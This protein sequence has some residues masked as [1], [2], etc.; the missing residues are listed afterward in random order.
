MGSI[1]VK[2]RNAQIVNLTIC[3]LVSGLLLSSNP[4]LA[5]DDTFNRNANADSVIENSDRQVFDGYDG[6]R[7]EPS[8]SRSIDAAPSLSPSYQANLEQR[9]SDM[10]RQLRDLTGKLETVTF[11]NTQLKTNLEK[12]QADFDMRLNE[13]KERV[14]T[15]PSTESSAVT[16]SSSESTLTPEDTNDVKLDSSQD[17]G[18]NSKTDVAPADSPTQQNLGTLTKAPNG[19]AIA[20]DKQADAASLYEDAYAALKASNHTDAQIKF[21]NFIK[22]NPTHPLRANAVYWLGETYYAQNNFAQ[23]TRVFAESYKKFPKG[24]KAADSLLKMGMSLGQNGK[25]KEACVTFKQL[26]KEF[27]VGQTALLRR[28]DAEIAKLSCS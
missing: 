18:E 3:V 16:P 17:S 28:A 24:P 15:S 27:N 1:V 14:N 4:S 9:L 23:A 7:D 10:E 8:P 2:I 26:K 11:E 13:V 22:Q 20:P 6:A 5:R 19:A 12:A 21:Q 25:T